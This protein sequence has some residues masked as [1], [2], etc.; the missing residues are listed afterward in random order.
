MKPE[1]SRHSF[2]KRSNVEIKIR[3]VGVELF[4]AGGQTDRQT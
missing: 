1:F 3:S 4:R 2:E